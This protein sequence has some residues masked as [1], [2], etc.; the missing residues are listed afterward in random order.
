MSAKPKPKTKKGGRVKRQA[1][2]S[3]DG[4]TVITHGIA[5]M[6]M[7]EK[8]EEGKDKD[9]GKEVDGLTSAKLN[10][11]FE[12]LQ[13]KWTGTGVSTQIAA[14]MAKRTGDVDGA[15][16][17]GIGSFARDWEHRWR[18]M[19]Q[20]VLFVEVVKLCGGDV[21]MYAQD[22]AFTPLDVEFLRILEIATLDAGI[23][24]HITPRAF[25]FSPFVDWF[26]LLP[27][28]LRG[29]DPALYVGNE[30]LADYT[31]FAQTRD[32]R[33]K[34]EECNGLG[35]AFLAGKDRV[36]LVDFELHAHALNGMV[37]YSTPLT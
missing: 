15:L 30:V 22:P 29:R 19:W 11:E 1:V 6:N 37:I 25:V 27:V 17:I 2:E 23:E 24:E 34:L 32:K 3:E 9:K 14:F 18:S 21:K 8:G 31:A 33:E 16:C 20:L 5:G 36:K 28:F 7:R 12:K 26:I 10:E 35:A 13:E 4:W